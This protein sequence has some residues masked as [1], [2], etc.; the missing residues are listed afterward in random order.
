MAAGNTACGRSAG[1]GAGSAGTHRETATAGTTVQAVKQ[2]SVGILTSS[3]IYRQKSQ[4]IY[5]Q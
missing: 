2:H 1:A 5:T 4:I 3:H